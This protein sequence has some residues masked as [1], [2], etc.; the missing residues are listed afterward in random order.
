[1]KEPFL[2][3]LP[4]IENIQKAGYEAYFVGGSVRDFLLGKE[5]H[6]VDIATSATP[7]EL[8]AIF[9]KTVDVGI[10]H[11]TII[12][13][14]KGQGFEVTTYRTEA[15]YKDYRR[16][17]SV[18][19]VRHLTEDLKRRDFTMN[20]IA[21]DKNGS[22]VDPFEGQKALKDKLIVTVGSADERFQE[23]AL[24]L[25][26]AI[27]FVSQ[28]GFRLESETEKAI[29]TY[30]HLLQHIAVERIMSEMAKILDGPYK[31]DAFLILLKSG[32]YQYLP[33]LFNERDVLVTSLDYSVST[34]NENQ[35]WLLAL[36]FS[37]TVDSVKQLKEWKLPAKKI[38][39][40]LRALDFLKLRIHHDWSAYHL[41]M[42]GRDIAVLVETVYQT[43]QH[44]P[45]D[46]S[47]KQ[48]NDHFDQLTI[49]ARNQLAVT[50]NDL[51]MWADAPGG[52]WVK[53][54][55]ENIIQAVLNE[56]VANDKDQIRRWI[57]ACGLL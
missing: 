10:A 6:D 28:L 42:A 51:L 38:K 11:G 52:P 14:R 22:L 24:R 2:S 39:V 44:K 8:K 43:I 36:H 41:F 13:I 4:I 35:M 49:K 32:L 25:M 47:V 18:S 57:K 31:T 12:V 37:H 16:P 53:E 3:A 54:L 56:D 15:D 5:I 29:G 50:G 26:R 27:R 7:T 48:V 30:A 21:M 20:A 17:E 23:D 9:P 45:V 19:F 40:L 46:S 34:L 1:M 33:S 55:L